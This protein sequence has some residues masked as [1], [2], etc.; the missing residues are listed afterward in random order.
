MRHPDDLPVWQ[1]VAIVAGV[2]AMA[3][4]CWVLSLV[5]G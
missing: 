3:L 2:A 1:E 5:G 4:L